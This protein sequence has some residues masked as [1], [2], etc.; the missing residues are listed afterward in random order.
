[1]AERVRVRN[2]TRG[3]VLAR[4]AQRADT[5]WSRFRGL[6]FQASLPAEEGLILEPCSSIHMFFVRFPIDVAFATSGGRVVA[7]IRGIRPWRMTRI[8]FRARLAVELPAGV[9]RSTGTVVGDEL[10][11]ER[12]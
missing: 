6:M 8:Y 4:R 2:R 12:N 7:A 11:F 5:W 3:T 9:L 10:L 1:V